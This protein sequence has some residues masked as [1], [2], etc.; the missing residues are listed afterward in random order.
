MALNKTQKSKIIVG[1]TGDAK[2]TGDT[3]AQISVLTAEIKSITE[4]MKANPKDFSTKRGLYKK[5]SQR[6]S[7]LT[8]L[9]NKDIEKYR[10]TL[11]ALEL[12]S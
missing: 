8:Y 9:K 12:R 5:V 7:L 2:N 10:N 11:V 3:V 6:K 4:H 1:A